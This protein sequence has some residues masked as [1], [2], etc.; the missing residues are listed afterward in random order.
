MKTYSIKTNH[1]DFSQLACIA[2][3]VWDVDL[4]I[5]CTCNFAAKIVQYFSFTFIYLNE[6][7]SFIFFSPN[8][9]VICVI[10]LT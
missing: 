8:F 6:V 7:F 2:T 1:S 4:E 5:K 3:Q 10:V 9:L